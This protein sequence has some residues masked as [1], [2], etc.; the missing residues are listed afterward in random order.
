[1]KSCRNTA[2]NLSVKQGHRYAALN[3]DTKETAYYCRRMWI[4]LLMVQPL[5]QRRLRKITLGGFPL[6]YAEQENVVVHTR[7]GDTIDGTLRLNEPAVHVPRIGKTERETAIWSGL[8]DRSSK[9]KWKNWV[10]VRATIS[11]D[12]LCLH[13]GFVSRHLDDKASAAV[14]WLA[15][16][17]RRKMDVGPLVT[18]MFTTFEEVGHGRQLPIQRY[19]GHDRRGYGCGGR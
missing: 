10:F 11:L 17:P 15:R 4:R 9:E 1:M 18:L 6:N 16:R 14:F 3:P 19:H 13:R 5:S 8:T 2:A 12:P 7:D